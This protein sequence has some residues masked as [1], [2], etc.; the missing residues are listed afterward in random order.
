M[1][2]EE[3]AIQITRAIYKNE[4]NLESLEAYQCLRNYFMD[5]EINDLRGIAT[6]YG[7]KS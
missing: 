1:E 5:L 7:V 2:K 3:I 6:Q 4:P